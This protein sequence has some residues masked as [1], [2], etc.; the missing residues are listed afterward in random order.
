VTTSI[1][2]R[3]NGSAHRGEAGREAGGERWQGKMNRAP[4]APR[5]AQA[6]AWG[7]RCAAGPSSARLGRA[8]LGALCAGLCGVGN[9]GVGLG[10]WAA[11]CWVGKW[12]AGPVGEGMARGNWAA[13][14]RSS[15]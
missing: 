10:S 12:P 3:K 6:R 2:E 7:C 14:A 9:E 5:S 4:T 1:R 8:G 11:R 13:G 15:P